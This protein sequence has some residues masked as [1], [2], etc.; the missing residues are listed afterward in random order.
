[1]NR[2]RSVSTFQG[3]SSYQARQVE[4]EAVLNQIRHHPL[5][6]SG[7]G[8]TVTWGK[9]H[10]FA[11]HTTNFAHEGYL[12]LA[13]KLG[14]PFALAVVGCLLYAALRRTKRSSDRAFRALR[15]GSHAGLLGSLAVCVTFPEF[16]A[17]G[18]TA[19][20]GL[21][22]AAC[23]VP[24]ATAVTAGGSSAEA[25]RRRFAPERIQSQN[26]WT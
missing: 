14:L 24:S 8:A 19:V 10:V 7:Y 23:L 15:V 4:A 16:N 9:R 17:L 3:Q 25:L 20:L 21:I 22:V 26:S 5:I 6:G 11:T 2:I 13:W 1:M 18:I 12:W